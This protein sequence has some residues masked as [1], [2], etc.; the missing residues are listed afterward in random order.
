MGPETSISGSFEKD[1]S[2]LS[3]EPRL[4]RLRTANKPARVKYLAKSCGCPYMSVNRG[5]SGVGEMRRMWQGSR[6]QRSFVLLWHSSNVEAAPSENH[7][8]ATPDRASKPQLDNCDPTP[9]SNL[10]V[11]CISQVINSMWQCIDRSHYQNAKY[12]SQSS[13]TFAQHGSVYSGRGRALYDGHYGASS[14]DQPSDVA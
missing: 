13:G 4:N 6:R 8:S 5:G 3:S 14:R 9:L 7:H 12:A 10:Q 2:S 11:L 1:V